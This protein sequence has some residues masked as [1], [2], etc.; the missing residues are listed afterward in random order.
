MSVDQHSFGKS[1]CRHCQGDGYLVNPG[2]DFAVARTC[3]CVPFCTA[4]Q[5]VG[6]RLVD[7]RVGRCRCQM[8]PDRIKRFNAA[9]I[10][11]VHANSSFRN[12]I[13]EASGRAAFFQAQGWAAS[14]RPGQN[15]KGFVLT[16]KVGR[17]KTHLMVAAMRYA[18]FNSGARARFVEFSHLI[19]DLKRSFEAGT[20]KVAMEDYFQADILAIDEL[21]K[22]RCTEWELSI[23]DELI[24]RA[25]N[26]RKTVL[27]STNFPAKPSTGQKTGNMSDGSIPALV[28]RV[29]DRVYSR[30]QAMTRMH[31]VAG[32][33][34]RVV[35]KRFQSR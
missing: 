8:L 27:A 26:G 30:L 29:G 10:P 5:G 34:F 16:G 1:D 32:E 20:S 19:A 15:A 25:Y 17:G 35:G 12:F 14:F 7:G 18:I 11:S 31:D 4:C 2:D 23:L 13:P 28:D 33:D 9:R 21:G 6:Q 22:G 24:S 3:M